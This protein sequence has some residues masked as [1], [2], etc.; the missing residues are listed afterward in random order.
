MKWRVNG[1]AVVMLLTLNT[2][3]PLSGRHVSRPH[4][5]TVS[6]SLAHKASISNV[7]CRSVMIFSC[8]YLLSSLAVK[9]MASSPFATYGRLEGG[10]RQE[11]AQDLLPTPSEP[12]VGTKRV[13]GSATGCVRTAASFAPTQC[14]S[15]EF[16]TLHLK[17][18]KLIQMLMT[19]AKN[20][21]GRSMTPIV[22]VKGH[23][24]GEG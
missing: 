4:L 23:I 20:T 10:N 3:S 22:R 17:H 8:Q 24:S 2:F 15:I 13:A 19:R 16:R 18:L 11:T 7:S 14:E 12:L 1:L 9:Q 5:F 21:S 6:F